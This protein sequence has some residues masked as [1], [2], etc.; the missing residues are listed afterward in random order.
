MALAAEMTIM[1]GMD[2]MA[3]KPIMT[4]IALMAT[5]TL[6]I[7]VLIWIRLQW[8]QRPLL[9]PLAAMNKLFQ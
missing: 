3:V 4:I 7:S 2:I 6:M 1:D 9:A 8:Q 5:M